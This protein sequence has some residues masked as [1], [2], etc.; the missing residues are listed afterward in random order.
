VLAAPPTPDV[1]IAAL[2]SEL[3]VTEGQAKKGLGALL[4][5]AQE[6]LLPQDFDTLLKVMPYADEYIQMA[7]MQGVV[8]AP[9]ED[10]ESLRPIFARLGIDEAA[11]A[12]FAPTVLSVL[13]NDEGLAEAHDLL[14]EALE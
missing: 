12:E 5:L 11:A 13:Q 10:G 14:A 9:L 4:T 3:G 7:R 6:R 2:E 1:I 8:V